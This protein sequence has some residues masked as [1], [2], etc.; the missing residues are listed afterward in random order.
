MIRINRIFGRWLAAVVRVYQ[1][2]IS[3]D[4]GV[5]RGWHAGGCCR[6]EPTCS[7]YTRQALIKYGLA[8]GVWMGAKRVIRC[9]PWSKGGYDPVK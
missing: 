4:H 9:N 8:R 1:V 5:A 6:F 7:E 2:T 3:P